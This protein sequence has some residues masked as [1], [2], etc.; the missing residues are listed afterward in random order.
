M[1]RYPLHPLLELTGWTMNRVT[2]IAPCNGTEYRLRL[3]D[4]VT[5]R[6]A[7]RLAVAA[8]L[9]PWAVWP[10]MAEDVSSDLERTCGADGC[11]ATFTPHERAPHARYCSQRCRQREK[12][13]RYRAKPHGAE[14]NRRHRRSYYEKNRGYELGQKRRQRERAALEREAA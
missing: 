6:T 7:D 3:A 9:H 4:G 5:E 14:T 12:A 2:Q 13:R 11:E 8:G 10:D 1:R